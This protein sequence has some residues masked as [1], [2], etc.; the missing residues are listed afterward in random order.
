MISCGSPPKTQ[1][2]SHSVSVGPDED[3]RDPALDNSRWEGPV[4]LGRV[5]WLITTGTLVVGVIVLALKRD[6]G[7]AGVSLAVAIS[8]GINLF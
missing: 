1:L 6:W 4:D 5:A 7:Y 2:K 3:T 8:A